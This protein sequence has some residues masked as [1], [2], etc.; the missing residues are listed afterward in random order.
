MAKPEYTASRIP[1]PG[2][3]RAAILANPD[4]VLKDLEI[5][6]VLAGPQ[7]VQP[8][9]NVIDLRGVA[10]RKLE[11]R[12]QE[13]EETHR[14]VVS[15]AYANAATTRRIHR[16]V[17]ALMKCSNLQVFLDTLEAYVPNQLGVA[18][19]RLLVERPPQARSP[20]HRLRNQVLVNRSPGSIARFLKRAALHSEKKVL[21]REIPGG[22]A[23]VY[24]DIGSQ[25]RSEAAIPLDFF[26]HPF[27]MLLL[28]GSVDGNQF[29]PLQETVLLEFF[30][31]SVVCLLEQH[32][33]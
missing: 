7:A 21:L 15:A 3:V 28:I 11:S 20:L 2:A 9:E 22:S 18:A 10:L 30:G 19:I 31:N 25:I 1:S 5:I 24:G 32:L 33:A 27:K 6:R 17:V 4:L 26:R 13:L 29:S 23:D 12:L 14:M 8:Q 16:V